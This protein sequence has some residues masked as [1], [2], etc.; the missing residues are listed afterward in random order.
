MTTRE[1]VLTD[2][3]AVGQEYDRLFPFKPGNGAPPEFP[4]WLLDDKSLKTTVD[5]MRKA[6][7]RGTP[8]TQDEI[9]AAFG[10]TAESWKW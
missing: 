3:D 6:I 10:L 4:P 9:N 5:L 7:A 1:Q 8:L 2:A